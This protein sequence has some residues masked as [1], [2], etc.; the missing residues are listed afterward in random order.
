MFTS[1]AYNHSYDELEKTLKILYN[2]LY[3]GGLVIF[4]LG[5][6]LDH[7]LGGSMWVD[8]YSDKDLQLARISQSPLEPKNGIFHGKMIFLV[9]DKGKVDF[10][11]DEHKL[12]VFEPEK[13]RAL[14]TKLGFEGYIYNGATKRLWNKRMKCAVV[15]VGVKD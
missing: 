7:W 11:I 1:M 4:D 13:I 12:G 5:I 15:F 14:M 10:E 8:T 2:H 6:H 9:K 3:P